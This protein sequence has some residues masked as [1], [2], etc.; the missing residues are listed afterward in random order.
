[1]TSTS[2]SASKVREAMSLV[3][4]MMYAK[5]T[6]GLVENEDTAAVQRAL[7]TSCKATHRYAYDIACEEAE[8]HSLRDMKRASRSLSRVV[9]ACGERL[10]SSMYDDVSCVANELHS[11]ASVAEKTRRSERS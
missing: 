2:L 7:E 6:P 8:Q 10:P 3:G 5:L 9:R 4:A 11:F 1:M